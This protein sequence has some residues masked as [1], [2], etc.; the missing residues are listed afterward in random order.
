MGIIEKLDVSYTDGNFLKHL[1]EVIENTKF[2]IVK[3]R[4]LLGVFK[5]PTNCRIKKA[6]LEKYALDKDLYELRI[7]LCLKYGRSSIYHAIHPKLGKNWQMLEK[8]LKKIK[9]DSSQKQKK[10]IENI[11]FPRILNIMLSLIWEKASMKVREELIDHYKLKP[12]H[13]C[14]ESNKNP[15]YDSSFYKK[16]FHRDSKN[17]ELIPTSFYKKHFNYFKNKYLKIKNYREYYYAPTMFKK[18]DEVLEVFFKN[19]EKAANEWCPILHYP[20]ATHTMEFQEY[21]K[22]YQAYWLLR[23]VHAFGDCSPYFTNSEPIFKCDS[24]FKKFMTKQKILNKIKKSICDLQ[25]LIAYIC[26]YNKKKRCSTWFKI[27]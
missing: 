3:K 2:N 12:E 21:Q 6:E 1:K 22:A 26:I 9:Y 11:K 18:D 19:V 15:Y 24:F 5:K 13:I 10:I 16:H 8:T 23:I 14:L 4:I 17:Y 25:N 27:F 20:L 7:I